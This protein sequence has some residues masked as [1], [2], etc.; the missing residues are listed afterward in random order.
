MTPHEG[1]GSTLDQ[2][3]A[4]PATPPREA[5]RPGP[6]TRSITKPLDPSRQT[7]RDENGPAGYLTPDEASIPTVDVVTGAFDDA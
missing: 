4:A 1:S 2:C 7:G 5:R 6:L 3:P